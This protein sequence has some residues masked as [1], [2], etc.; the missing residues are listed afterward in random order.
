[1]M[2]QSPAGPNKHSSSLLIS[3]HHKP[4]AAGHLQRWAL[5]RSSYNYTIEFRST[6]AHANAAVVV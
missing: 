6:K 4:L 2:G 3:E 1:M 5:L